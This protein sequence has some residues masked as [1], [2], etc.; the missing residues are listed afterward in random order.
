M[1]ACQSIQAEIHPDIAILHP[2]DGFLVEPA[3]HLAVVF[4][5]SVFAIER[6][7]SSLLGVRLD[8]NDNSV[9]E[10]GL[11]IHGND[12]TAQ[13]HVSIP[14]FKNLGSNLVKFIW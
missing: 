3:H 8:I 12:G 14:G 9:M 7:G 2:P 4:H 1:L 11:L 6:L 13:Y 10:S 5:V